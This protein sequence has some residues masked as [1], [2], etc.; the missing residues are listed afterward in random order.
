MSI[1]RFPEGFEWGVATAAAQIEGGWDQGG[2]G[3]SIWD[4]FSARPGAIKGGDT[5]FVACD[6]YHRFEDDLR[7][8][9]ELGIKHY[10]LSISWPRIFPEGRGEPNPEGVAF[11]RK[12]LSS[13]RARGI[14]PAVT[15]YH[16]DLPQALQDEGGWLER[17]TALDFAAYAKACFEL[18]GDLVGKWITH[19]EPQVAAVLG[20]ELGVHAPGLKLPEKARQAAHHLLLSHGLAVREFRKGG[21]KGEIG[22]TLNMGY[23]YPASGEGADA[24]A[25]ELAFQVGALWYA[26]PVLKGTYPLRAW[27]EFERLG[28]APRIEAGDMDI[29]SEPVDFLGVNYYS[30]NPVRA[31]PREVA[32]LGYQN[33]PTSLPKTHIGWDIVPEG[34]HW[35][36][37]SLA[38][39]YP[40]TPLYVTENG[41]CFDGEPE[42]GQD[43][44]E[45]PDRLE[46]L[47]AHFVQAR[48]AIAEGVP[49]RGYYVWSLM[50]NFEWA[51]GYAKRFGIVH[52]DFKTQKRTPKRSALWFSAVAR[53]NEVDTEVGAMAAE[54]ALAR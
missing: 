24:G 3:E 28:Q 4:R 42:P 35:L 48:R 21:H 53:T 26:D 12:L 5:T 54:P 9:E 23:A 37:R 29:I 22:I 39:R 46:Y 52:V 16:W 36:L 30:G 10:R 27:Q 18:F 8:I 19:N 25:A 43:V 33:A 50:D 15:L 49:L 1:V 31:V 51:E 45:D 17:R 6:H 47:R 13:L 38:S 41:A 14:E 20:Y 44:Q 40:G 11:Y 34:L 2:K 7:L 32:P